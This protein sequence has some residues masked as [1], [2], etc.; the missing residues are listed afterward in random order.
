[1]Y[2]FFQRKILNLFC[3]NQ[4]TLFK[5]KEKTFSVLFVLFSFSPRSNALLQDFQMFS[6]F[7]CHTG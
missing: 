6:E 5:N 4:I 7:R 1:M 2:V 3:V